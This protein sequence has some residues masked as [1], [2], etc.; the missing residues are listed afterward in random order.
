MAL[1]TSPNLFPGEWIEGVNKAAVLGGD[2]VK[3]NLWRIVEGF[4]ATAIIKVMD[5]TSRLAVGSL[6]T[7]VAG[8]SNTMADIAV[9]LT[10]FVIKDVVCKD[11]ILG[12]NYDA[13]Q[14]RGVFNKVIPAEVLQAYVMNMANNE[15][16]NLENIR[17]S[18]DIAGAGYIALQ[19]GIIVKAVAAGTT[20][21]VVAVAITSANVIAEINRVIAATPAAIRIR[22]NFKL[23]VS[24]EIFVAY[25]AAMSAN[26]ATATYAVL[27]QNGVQT[28]QA[29]APSYVGMF[30]G[31]TIPMYVASGLSV[32]Y[33]GVMLAGNFSNDVNGNL[34]YVTD[35]FSDL[36]TIQ[37]QDRQNVFISENKVDIVWAFRQGMEIARYNE[38]VLYI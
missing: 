20:I 11:D 18:G 3:S 19:D 9:A 2:S 35:A 15:S 4:E 27:G 10:T 37:V 17:W 34:I 26:Q 29:T 38:V 22:P 6:C 24:Y 12:T 23:I 1:S 21:P 30:V 33:P 36:S 28:L 13:F 16:Q 32:S 5:Y 14:Q 8:T 7:A 25:E 31:T